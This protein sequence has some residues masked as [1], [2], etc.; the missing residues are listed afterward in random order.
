MT[1]ARAPEAM[2]L[3]RKH[4]T[5]LRRL[6]TVNIGYHLVVESGFARLAKLPPDQH[7]AARSLARRNGTR[8]GARGYTML[9]LAGAA[10]L[11]PGVGE[12]ILLSTLVTQIRTDAAQQGIPL[13]DGIGDRRQLVAALAVLLEWGVL[14]EVDGTLAQWGE[15]GDEA[16][17]TICRPLLP[18][19][20]VKSIGPGITSAD[21]IAP[22]PDAPRRSLRR[23]LVEE[24]VVLRS[25]LGPE[26]L[27]VLS[28]ERSELTRMLSDAFGLVLE[29]RAEGA[30]GY[31]PGGALSDIEFP[32]SGTVKQAAL[33]LISKLLDSVD[34]D[35][36]AMEFTWPLVDSVVSDLL[37]AHGRAWRSEYAGAPRTLRDDAVEL[38]VSLRLAQTTPDTLILHAAAA[39]YRPRPNS[40]G[41][42]LAFE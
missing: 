6:F 12:Q 11:A 1:A 37:R 34:D 38:L 28:R 21:V 25:D 2:A 35:A 33:L 7:A 36:T 17:L 13:S 20:L 41:T 4:S 16:L 8:F 40:T 5:A 10:L 29:V 18:H 24:P 19:L 42:Q 9:A 14:T 32:G 23:R 31:D 26:E 39:R 3:I 22:Q 27:D 15:S 30:L